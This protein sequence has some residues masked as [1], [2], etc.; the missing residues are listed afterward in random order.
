M[1][2]IPEVCGCRGLW[3]YAVAVFKTGDVFFLLSHTHHPSHLFLFHCLGPSALDEA[4]NKYVRASCTLILGCGHIYLDLSQISVG[5]K[6]LDPCGGSK[7]TLS[8]SSTGSPGITSTFLD[9]DM[10]Q[11]F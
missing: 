4:Y 3:I 7:S 5:T 9:G 2:L 1:H 10:P 11:E 6:H 8:A